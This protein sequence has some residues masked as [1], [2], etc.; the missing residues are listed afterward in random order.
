MVGKNNKRRPFR[1]WFQTLSISALIDEADKC[2]KEGLCPA[3]FGAAFCRCR[4]G[5]AGWDTIIYYAPGREK[6]QTSSMPPN[7]RDWQEL[8]SSFQADRLMNSPG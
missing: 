1:H 6:S 2:K 3:V 7:L 8:S 5:T 4:T